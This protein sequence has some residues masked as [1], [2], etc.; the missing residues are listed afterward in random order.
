MKRAIVFGIG[1]NFIFG[2]KYIAENYDVIG[3]ADNSDE[4]QG[5]AYFGYAVRRID[6]YDRES[7]DDVV[8]TPSS[9][10]AMIEQLMELGIDKEHIISLGDMLSDAYSNRK[11][12]IAVIFYGGMGDFI[13]GKNWLYHLNSMFGIGREEI[14]VL[15]SESEISTLR[16]LFSDCE[17]ISGIESIDYS[18]SNLVGDGFDLALRFCIFPYVQSM[19][20]EVVSYINPKL[21][22]YA[23]GVR[24]FGL[25]NYVPGFF[26]SPHFY[27]TVGKLFADYPEKKY[28]SHFD[29]LGNLGIGDEYLCKIPI[30]DGTDYLKELGV[31]SGK[32]ITLD[33]GLNREY[34]RKP[35]T[36]AWKI[37][38]WNE[39]ALLLKKKYPN[40]KVIQIGLKISDE[41][42][43]EADLNLNGKTDLEQVK[44]LMKNALLHVDYDGGLIHLRHVLKGGP[45]VVLYGPSADAVH[46]YPENIS[47]QANV[48]KPCEWTS[49]DW[50]SN[51]PKGYSYPKCMEAITPQMVMDRIEGFGI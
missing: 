33:T 38:D 17:W 39:L 30:A 51:C 49:P 16:N 10:G 14:K 45:S 35:N 29:V 31:S 42:D 22:E 1:N 43:I 5:K 40:T 12:K 11:L 4:K 24:E 20:D 8:V 19:A 48:C 44:I 3:L 32:F 28:H 21:Y 6:E 50:L 34:S 46:N 26:A 18:D 36:R 2:F 25:K 41:D 37:A 27:K 13:I 47:V 7:F 9:A 23:D 15:C